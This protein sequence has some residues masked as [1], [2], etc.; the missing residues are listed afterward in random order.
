VNRL[1]GVLKDVGVGD[2]NDT[3]VDLDKGVGAGSVEFDDTAFESR[4]GEHSEGRGAGMRMG[5][6]CEVE[7]CATQSVA[8]HFGS[9][10]VGI[11]DD[12]PAIG[13]WVRGE[14]EDAIGT[15]AVVAVTQGD[16]LGRREGLVGFD[17]NEVV[18]QAV[19]F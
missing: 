17:E 5:F 2:V 18:S 13:A 12:H 8:A 14:E 7:G 9:G 6:G 16:D 19:V 11:E 10:S 4:I 15:D 3:H 1:V